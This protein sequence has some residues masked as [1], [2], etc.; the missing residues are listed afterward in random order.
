MSRPVGRA[1]VVYSWQRQ[2]DD[3][4][5]AGHLL[6]SVMKERTTMSYLL[7]IGVFS[8]GCPDSAARDSV[9][10]PAS[11]AYLVT[12][13]WGIHVWQGDGIPR[14][15]MKKV[16]ERRQPRRGN[17][18][19]PLRRGVPTRNTGS[20]FTRDW[21]AFW[22]YGKYISRIE[23]FWGVPAG[24]GWDCKLTGASETSVMGTCDLWRCLG[25]V[26][27]RSPFIPREQS[28]ILEVSQGAI[29]VLSWVR[30]IHKWMWE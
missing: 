2:D 17:Y 26:A 27:K 7:Y 30:G 23:E 12:R 8:R 9:T 13:R 14:N 16:G 5:P 21:G 10:K 18:F 22:N 28:R 19:T 1:I 24:R 11:E 29:D 25:G 20:L 6:L 3:G 15:D 4:R